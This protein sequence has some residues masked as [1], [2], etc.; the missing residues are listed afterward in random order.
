MMQ[1]GPKVTFIII[2]GQTLVLQFLLVYFWT[3]LGPKSVEPF[4]VCPI[5]RNLGFLM[6]VLQLHY[7][8]DKCRP[9]EIEGVL[10]APAKFSHLFQCNSNKPSL[11]LNI[12]SFCNDSLLAAFC[13]NP[14]RSSVNER[15]SV[16]V[17]VC[18]C[19]RERESR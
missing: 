8:N 18:V 9:E 1:Y 19:V 6:Q 12:D 14:F 2:S 16:C 15:M 5:A 7:N 4:F 13:K 3:N 17:C 10:L 11:I